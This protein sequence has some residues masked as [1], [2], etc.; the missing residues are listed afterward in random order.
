MKT[1]CAILIITSSLCLKAWSQQQSPRQVVD[2]RNHITYYKVIGKPVQEIPGLFYPN[3][4]FT[5][6]VV[7]I[8]ENMISDT[9]KMRYHK[10]NDVIQIQSTDNVYEVRPSSGASE[11]HIGDL[12]LT[13]QDFTIKGVTKTGFFELLLESDFSL[14]TK[15]IYKPDPGTLSDGSSSGQPSPT[16]AVVGNSFLKV[17]NGSPNGLGFHPEDFE[18]RFYG[19][20]DGSVLVEMTKIKKSGSLFPKHKKDLLDYAKEHRLLSDRQGFMRLFS[21]YNSLESE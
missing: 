16:Y 6:G 2:Y 5:E 9:L 17:P 7:F 13:P 10:L 18:R 15:E 3:D 8:G 20:I 11:I 21:Y 19:R 12:V 14:L 1:V 4:E